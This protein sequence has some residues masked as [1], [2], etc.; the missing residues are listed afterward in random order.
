M[1]NRKIFVNRAPGLQS[2]SVTVRRCECVCV[3]CDK[4][5]VL[6]DVE[7]FVDDD[8]RDSLVVTDSLSAGQVM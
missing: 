1:I 6:A 4:Y 3:R 2:L 7:R 5:V 8:P